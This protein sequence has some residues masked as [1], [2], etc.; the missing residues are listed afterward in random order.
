MMADTSE[1]GRLI[2]CPHRTPVK[3]SKYLVKLVLPDPLIMLKADHQLDKN[4]GFWDN[5]E[6]LDNN[7]QAAWLAAY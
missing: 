2:L 4:S 7:A 5:R 1:A 3:H 6:L